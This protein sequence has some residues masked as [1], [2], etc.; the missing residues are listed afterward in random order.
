LLFAANSLSPRHFSL[1][2]SPDQQTLV[3]ENLLHQSL[4]AMG[5]DDTTMAHD[6]VAAM[7]RVLH[8]LTSSQWLY[9]DDPINR[10]VVRVHVVHTNDLINIIP[11][12]AIHPSSIMSP[13]QSK[14]SAFHILHRISNM[15][16]QSGDSIPPLSLNHRHS[17][18][19]GLDQLT[20]SRRSHEE[21][22]IQ[23]NSNAQ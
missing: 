9:D 22:D 18:Y 2:L 16:D 8:A 10:T 23:G 19:L 17:R 5:Y 20:D 12:L 21:A 1:S 11:S 7:A 14:S 4:N 15:M 3:T 6:K 13:G